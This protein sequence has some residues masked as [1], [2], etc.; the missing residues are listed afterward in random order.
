MMDGRIKTLLLMDG[1]INLTVYFLVQDQFRDL[2]SPFGS[3]DIAA[4]QFAE[5]L[6]MGMGGTPLA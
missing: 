5:L 6:N 4:E 3:G 1:F 2:L